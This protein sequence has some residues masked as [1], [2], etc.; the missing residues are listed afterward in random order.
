MTTVI[1]HKLRH[2]HKVTLAEVDG[3][4]LPGKLRDAIARLLSP[5]L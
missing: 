2:A 5:Y 4:S 1:Q 3:R